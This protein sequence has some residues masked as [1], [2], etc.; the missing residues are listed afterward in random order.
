LTCDNSPSI[1]KFGVI[2]RERGIIVE[3][4]LGIPKEASHCGFKVLQLDERVHWHS[5]CH[6]LS[7]W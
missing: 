7:H 3:P 5:M 6:K 4:V 2:L 1:S